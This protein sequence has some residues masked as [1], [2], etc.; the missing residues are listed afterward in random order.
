MSGY[1]IEDLFNIL[2]IVFLLVWALVLVVVEA[3]AERRA[4]TLVLATLGMLGALVFSVF[5]FG[6]QATAFK[7]ML[8]VDGYAVFIYILVLTSG[9]LSIGLAYDYNKRMGWARGEYYISPP[10]P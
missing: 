6:T 7:E 8:T 4:L 10:G 1:G 2:P 3:F 5:Q 9:L